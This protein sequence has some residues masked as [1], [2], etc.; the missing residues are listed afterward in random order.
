MK[1]KNENGTWNVFDYHATNDGEY[2]G[3][4][5]VRDEWLD[6]IPRKG[7]VE[8]EYWAD[9]TL[10]VI[11]YWKKEVWYKNVYGTWGFPTCY[12]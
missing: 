6:A 10:K 11:Y 7:I 9:G 8:I 5:E 4:R 2:I 3:W 12:H 1:V